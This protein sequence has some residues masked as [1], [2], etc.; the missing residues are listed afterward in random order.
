MNRSA[1]NLL[2]VFTKASKPV[3]MNVARF[4]TKSVPR[5]LITQQITRAVPKIQSPFG[6]VRFYGEERQPNRGGANR[7]NFKQDPPLTTNVLLIRAPVGVDVQSAL[8]SFGIV[9]NGV[10]TFETGSSPYIFIEFNSTEDA[11]RAIRFIRSRSRNPSSEIGNTTASPSS[12][13]E[14]E[15]LRQQSS[16][17]S[18]VAV[19]PKVPF[20]FTE[21]DLKEVF[22]N[23]NFASASVGHGKAYV[24]FNTPEEADKFI[25]QAGIATIGKYPV[26]IYKSIDF[27]MQRHSR[28][29]VTTVKIRGAPS[30]TTEDDVRAFLEGLNVNRVVMSS[31]EINGGRVINEIYVTFGDTQSVDAA[32]AKDREKIGSRWVSVRRSSQKEV[33]KSLERKREQENSYRDNEQNE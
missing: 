25:E 6:L 27:D 28:V 9:E 18:S 32:V 11:T 12:A 5:T 33:R 26:N 30:E 21:A 14:I 16:K 20:Y 17:P 22:P 19:L 7:R 8:S 24:K 23:F 10:H 1:I 31:V 29:P 4:A 13:E 3:Q 15:Q 2:S